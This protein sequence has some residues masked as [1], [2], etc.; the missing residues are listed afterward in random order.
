M[1]N[2]Y[3]WPGMRTGA[4]LQT[5][6]ASSLPLTPLSKLTAAFR[7]PLNAF[8]SPSLCFLV[9]I[10]VTLTSGRANSCLQVVCIVLSSFRQ[11]VCVT[12]S[13]HQNILPGASRQPQNGPSGH[14]VD[15]FPSFRFKCILYFASNQ[16]VS[17]LLTRRWRGYAKRGKSRKSRNG[18]RLFALLRFLICN[19]FVF[20]WIFA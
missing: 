6:E 2:Q 20:W 9:L 13:H 12:I 8:A 16:F 14:S 7:F 1:A 11:S 18:L 3:L 10:R 4:W 5:W 19:A 15:R 17:F